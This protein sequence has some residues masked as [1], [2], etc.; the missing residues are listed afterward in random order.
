MTGTQ[1]VPLWSG[2]GKLSLKVRQ[3]MGIEHTPRHFLVRKMGIVSR[4]RRQ[5][6]VA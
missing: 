5:D 4:L 6:Y 1:A 3:E 2:V